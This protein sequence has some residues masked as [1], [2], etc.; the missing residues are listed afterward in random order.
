[1]GKNLLPNA[2]FE[3]SFGEQIPTNWGDLQNVLTLKLTATGQVPKTPPEIERQ[4]QTVDGEHVA[5][6]P[7]ERVDGG[8][9][10]ATGPI[11]HLTS[12]AVP[13]K[14]GRAYTLSVHACSSTPSTTLELAFWTRPLDWTGQPDA[15]SHPVPMTKTWQ[16]LSFTFVTD[17]LVDFG[18]VDLIARSFWGGTVLVD[19][20]QLEE[21]PAATDFE[22]RFPVEASLADR[23]R[24][25]MLH[26][27]GEPFQLYLTTYNYAKKP[28]AGGMKLRIERLLDGVEVFTHTISDPVP[29]GRREQKLR[30]DFPLVGEFRATLRSADD[31][32]IGVDDYIFVVHPV[33]DE[34]FQGVLYSRECKIGKLPAERVWLPW[35]NKQNWHA[36]APQ[37]L[38]VTHDDMVYAPLTESHMARTPD[39]GRT[40]DILDPGRGVATVLRDGTFIAPAYEEDRKVLTF[41]GSR[42]EGKTWERA[43]E[44]PSAMGALAGPITKLADGGLIVPVGPTGEGVLGRALYVHRSSDGGR[45]WSEGYPVCPRAE[46][47]IIELGPDRLL[48]VVRDNTRVLPDDWQR[49]FRN[50]M[51]W[52]YWQRMCRLADLGSYVKRLLLAES[53]DGGVTWTNVHPGT[54]LLGEMHG[55]AVALPGGRRVRPAAASGRWQAWHDPDG[56]GRAIR[57]QLG[58][59]LRAPDLRGHRVSAPHAGNPLAAAGLMV[60]AAWYCGYAA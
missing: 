6:I 39:G 54:F 18:V 24:S 45:T 40:W 25:G 46:P 43:M 2:S 47:Q 30:L 35:E 4:A 20:V 33:I 36:S 14:Q 29:P 21:G 58:R 44:I 28:G 38:T 59:R 53:D 42:T 5:A 56:G 50:E 11:G 34:D 51:A 49:C 57:G 9:P 19:A 37:G 26:F 32:E 17:Q 23:R 60:N 1:M 15:L 41:Y 31:E 16:R 27:M 55:G 13:I 12:P 48:A 52:R 7:L 8:A 22:T 10:G 3:L